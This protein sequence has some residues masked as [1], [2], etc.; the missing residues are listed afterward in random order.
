MIFWSLGHSKFVIK[1][2][3]K[4]PFEFLIDLVIL[5]LFIRFDFK[6]FKPQKFVEVSLFGRFWS[7]RLFKSFVIL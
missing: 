4:G 1:K 2:K 6:F 3:K 5:G 7:I